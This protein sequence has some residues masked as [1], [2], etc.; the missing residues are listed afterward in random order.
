[1][2]LG[3]RKVPVQEVEISNLKSQVNSANT[4]IKFRRDK[5]KKLKR[6]PDLANEINFAHRIKQKDVE[7]FKLNDALENKKDL[8]KSITNVKKELARAKARGKVKLRW[9]I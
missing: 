6:R 3:I 7:K 4:E 8:L 5:L 1:M 9:V 2:V